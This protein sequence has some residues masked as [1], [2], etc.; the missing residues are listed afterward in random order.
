MEVALKDT[1]NQTWKNDKSSFGFKMLQKMGWNEQSGLGKN[2][3][4]ATTSI[5]VKKRDDGLGLG[6]VQDSA[7]NHGWGA[8]SSSFNQVLD[9]LKATYNNDNETKKSNKKR[10]VTSKIQVGIKYKRLS[11]AKDL[12]DKSA[13]DLRAV[14]GTGSAS[15]AEVRPQDGPTIATVLH[16]CSSSTGGGEGEGRVKRKSTDSDGSGVCADAGA[17][18]VH[19]KAKKKK[20]R[21][22]ELSS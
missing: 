3:N 21:R 14:L 17:D 12:S 13:A 5:K 1:L 2:E 15:R 7:G 4:G 22:S 10:K 8:T 11:A 9:M 18:G 6:M 19:K 16:R 20:E